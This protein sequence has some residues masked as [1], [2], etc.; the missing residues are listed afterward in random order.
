MKDFDPSKIID[1]SQVAE[2]LEI[3]RCRLDKKRISKR[4]K[5]ILKSLENKIQEWW[6]EKWINNDTRK[7]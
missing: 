5:L 7:S 1:K 4:N 6:D 3:H 2:L